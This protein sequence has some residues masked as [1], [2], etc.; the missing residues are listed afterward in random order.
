[1]SQSIG[2]G[3][4]SELEKLRKIYKS[5]GYVFYPLASVMS[6]LGRILRVFF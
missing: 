2:L 5:L 4:F 3:E 6:V 1:M